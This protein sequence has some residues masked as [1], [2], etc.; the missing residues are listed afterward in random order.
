MGRFTILFGVLLA[1]GTTVAQA[2][3]KK[4][5]KVE[6]LVLV[7]N[8][9]R[10]R[11]VILSLDILTADTWNTNSYMGYGARAD[12]NLLRYGTLTFDYRKGYLDGNANGGKKHKST[13]L[14]AALNLFSSHKTR[15]TQVVLSSSS[16]AYGTK[17]LH[18]TSSIEV[19]GTRKKVLQAR[20]GIANF[21]AA[22]DES[23]DATGSLDRDERYFHLVKDTADIVIGYGR[24]YRGVKGLTGLMKMQTWYVGISRRT[25][26]NLVIAHDEGLASNSNNYNIFFDLLFGGAP[27]FSE[28]SY[29]YTAAAL[30]NY[31]FPTGT[32]P[33]GYE[34]V[35]KNIKKGGW[36]FGWEA[37]TNNGVGMSYKVEF[38]SR[39]G[40]HQKAAIFKSNSYLLLTGGISIAPGKSYKKQ[41]AAL[42]K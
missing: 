27:A 23:P 25:I 14:G 41:A 29:Y 36:R 21:R 30:E 2:Q 17:M 8:P 34:L 42:E 33:A 20:V 37:K 39:P 4:G 9:D 24:G 35:N 38:G 1:A 7:D 11:P 13:E 22:I 28:M 6:Y 12:V 31:G 16:I 26:N 5:S 18:K 32:L 10:M 40:Y 15:P 3:H 19:T